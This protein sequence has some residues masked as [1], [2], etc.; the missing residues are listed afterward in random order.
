MAQA[1]LLPYMVSQLH[2][3]ASYYY[4]LLMSS[5]SALQ[6]VGSLLSG[7]QLLTASSWL[8]RQCQP[9]ML[10]LIDCRLSMFLSVDGALHSESHGSFNKIVSLSSA[11]NGLPSTGSRNKAGINSWYIIYI[12]V[13]PNLPELSPKLN[14]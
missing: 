10:Q 8:L 13:E 12:A 7:M 2:A 5:F 14:V 1:P 11:M 3:D 9:G 6:L 4:G